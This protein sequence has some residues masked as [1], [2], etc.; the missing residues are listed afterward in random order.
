[1]DHCLLHLRGKD[2]PRRKALQ[3][4]GVIA[5]LFFPCAFI[6]I[7]YGFEVGHV[8]FLRTVRIVSRSHLIYRRFR[9]SPPPHGNA[10]YAETGHKDER[11]NGRP[12]EYRGHVGSLVLRAIVPSRLAAKWLSRATRMRKSWRRSW[13]ALTQLAHVE[14]TDL[15]A[16]FARSDAIARSDGLKSTANSV[17]PRADRPFSSHYRR[18]PA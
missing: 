7:V 12:H 10:R 15:R 6:G 16:I 13:F 1:M 14:A 3:R 18:Y 8:I 4:R 17:A 5:K 11:K 2:L 9:P